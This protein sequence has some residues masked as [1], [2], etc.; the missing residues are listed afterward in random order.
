VPL[1][2]L[3]VHIAYFTAWIDERGGLHFAKDVYRYDQP[4]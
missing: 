4:P 3:P 1:T 2:R